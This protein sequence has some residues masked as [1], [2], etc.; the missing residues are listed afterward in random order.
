M[1]VNELPNSVGGRSILGDDLDNILNGT[2][3][4]DFI[5][6]F[7]GHDKLSGGAGN[8]T[9]SGGNGDDVFNGSL[10]GGEGSESDA[11]LGDDTMIGGAGDDKFY[12][13]A[14]VN[15]IDAGD[16]NDEVELSDIGFNTVHGGN[17]NDT[18]VVN[19]DTFGNNQIFGDAGN[20]EIVLN[21]GDAGAGGYNN[22]LS[23]GLGDDTFKL[24]DINWSTIHGDEGNDHLDIDGY[25]NSIDG[26]EG[27]DFL[28]AASD[29]E[30][31][32]LNGGEGNDTIISTHVDGNHADGGVGGDDTF[33]LL[34]DPEEKD[35]LDGLIERIDVNTLKIDE[36]G[37]YT[38]SFDGETS[39]QI[40]DGVIYDDIIEGDNIGVTAENFENLQVKGEVGRSILSVVAGGDAHHV[41]QIGDT[42]TIDANDFGS[43]DL[44][45]FNTSEDYLNEDDFLYQ[46]L[47]DLYNLDTVDF[48]IV[49]NEKG[50]GTYNIIFTNSPSTIT[51]TTNW[52][53]DDMATQVTIENVT[54]LTITSATAQLLMNAGV[55]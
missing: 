23:G 26:G 22:F 19:D 3:F 1:S 9:M 28:D 4:A 11:G 5:A 41:V 40:R 39:F 17:G 18:L 10:A 50:D 20:D 13:D 51:L 34:F 6:G 8:D 2:S 45:Q 27:D 47:L 29:A 14:G 32:K 49:E 46:D 30:N 36:E 44:T 25:N 16:G 7:D 15:T 24:D 48:E 55:S 33:F 35:I 43:I 54:N 21:A 53:D 42:G 12:D 37:N 31:N 38:F 52:A